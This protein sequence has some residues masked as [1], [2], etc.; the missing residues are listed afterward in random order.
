MADFNVLTYIGE[1]F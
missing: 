1:K